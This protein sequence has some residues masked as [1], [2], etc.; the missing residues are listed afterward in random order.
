MVNRNKD[1]KLVKR[2][3]D[4][5]LSVLREK[6]R[7]VDEELSNIRQ[8]E[9][10]IS[11][12]RDE[13][14]LDRFREARLKKLKEIHAKRMEFFNQGYGKLIEVDSDS[15]FFDVAR[16]TKYVVAHFSRPTTVRSQYLDEKMYEIC[17]TY[18]NTKF[19]KVNVEKTPFLCQRFNIWCL[20][21]LM[22]IIDGKTNHSIIG[23]HEFGGDG[24]TLD[25]FTKVLN[26]HK[27]LPPQ[28]SFDNDVEN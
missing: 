10:K 8:V 9:S 16:N 15:H 17:Q 27:I 25:E 20:P 24:F 26:K 12:L 5:V 19:I 6:E 7:E 4:N 2:V 11:Q 18:F 14:T 13:D 23:F 21:T 28:M 1:D 22:I 3:H